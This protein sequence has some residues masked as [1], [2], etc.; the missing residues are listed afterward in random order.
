MIIHNFRLTL[1]RFARQ[2]LNTFL[3]IVGL[4]LGI[5]VCTLIGL[6]LHYEL[7]F[8]NYHNNADRI[9]RINSIWTDVGKKIYHFSTP[10][11]L[12]NALRTEVSGLEHVVL[13]HPQ[14]NNIVEI[15]PEKRFLQ[16]H[17]LITEPEFLN[18]F[19]VDVLKGNGYKALR[20]PY[21]ALLTQ[22]TA[23]KFF[24]NEDPVGKT[25]KYK[26]DFTITVAGII[27][28]LPSN[29]HLPASILLSYV[30]DDKFLSGGH[31]SWTFVSGTATY[32]VVPENYNLKNLEVQLKRIADK[33][34][35]SNEGVLK[36][37][38][39]DFDIQLLSDIHFNSKYA[40]GSQWVQAVNVD[41]L[42]FFAGIGLAVLILACINFVNLSTAQ[43][44]TRAKEVG[45]RK[46]IGA[47]RYQLISQFLKEAWMLAF[48]AGIF[49]ISITKL[50]LP[51]INTLLEKHITFDLSDSPLI[52]LT[53]LAG[54]LLIGLL[55]GLYPAFIIAKF[56][57]ALV[58]KTG[59]TVTGDQRS[60]W[61]RKGL[62]ITQFA[63]SA[64]LLIAV[65]V[66]AQQ[67]SYMH[68]KNLGFDKDNIV[69]TQIK[70]AAKAAVFAQ[71][72]KQIPQV[73]GV[74][75]ATAPPSSENH[76]STVMS[77]TNADDPN[78]TGVKLIIADDAYGKLY[79]LKLL[80]GRFLQAS[81]TNYIS[82]S[83]PEDKRI[84]KVVV[85]E[86]LV[87]AAGFASN[88]AAV[89]K[90]FWLGWGGSAEIIGVVANFNVTSLHDEITPTVIGEDPQMYGEANIKIAKNSDLPQTL[91][92]I[93]AAWKKTFPDGVFTFKFLDEQID[94]FYKSE[95]RLYSLFR[96]FAGLAMLISC[97]GLWGLAAFAAQ[98]KTKEIGI[99]KVLGASV[100]SIV[101]LLSKDFL[102]M[103]TL[104]LIIAS[105]VAWY[106]MHQ[107]LQNFAY[108]ISISSW[109][110]CAAG[111]LA[112]LIAIATVSFHA[113]K[114]AI[115]NPV[116]SLRTE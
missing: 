2:K 81:D 15:T 68:S 36:G 84:H 64:G 88:E 4:T 89:G 76:W 100:M 77:L 20:K 29:T 79:G 34:I 101:T 46:S 104:A 18:V 35:N 45:V 16:D 86:K 113:I 71:E 61:L 57:P 40:G 85:N 33:N 73:K 6:F 75:F 80:S 56:N 102:K 50:S 65:F 95:A 23:K 19:K 22:A 1:R 10:T 98:Q 105:P 21:Q 109:I 13:A 70:V 41:W 49:S 32:V 103:V 74:S 24:G 112:V 66:I 99:R 83:S 31:N 63:I 5:S 93:E 14:D 92:G 78:R 94:A 38:R 3:H 47:S 39:A 69:T 9:Y 97:L 110:L 11:P 53:L 59:T 114:A 58:L 30:A 51:S 91:A 28:D 55:A 52:L 111:L 26:N 48:I 72:L 12:A 62:V 107:W 115:A 17:V 44:L 90:R 25:F 42:W 54:I 37:S 96:I 8:D 87:Q 7:S 108:R 116:K 82:S 106:F 43:A 27:R 67:V 60:A